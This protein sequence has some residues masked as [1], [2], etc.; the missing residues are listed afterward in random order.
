MPA[1]AIEDVLEPLLHLGQRVLEIEI[2]VALADLLA[3]LLEKL[4]E[5]HHARAV[6][7]E[8]LARQPVDRL[9]HVV[10]VG[11]ILGELL[12]HLVG[13]KPELLAPVPC[14]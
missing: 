3:Q 13:V 9:A 2:A 10:G 1:L 14:V 12:Q 6:E 11:E 7:V 4:V 8:A 5:A